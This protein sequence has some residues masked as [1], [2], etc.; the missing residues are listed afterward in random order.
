VNSKN[1]SSRVESRGGVGYEKNYL[2]SGLDNCY[3]LINFT[4]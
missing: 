2:L 3:S 1:P 4:V